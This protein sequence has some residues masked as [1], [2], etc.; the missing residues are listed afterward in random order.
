LINSIEQ[1]VIKFIDEK[2]LLQ[3]KD[4]VLVAFSGGP[5]SVFLLYF[6]NKFKRRFH[7]ELAAL[8][9]NHKLR[10]IEANEDE[11][12]CRDFCKNLSIDFFSVKKD[13]KSFATKRKISL[14]EAGR[15]IRYSELKKNASRNKFNKIATAHNSNDNTETI[16]LNLIKGTGIKGISG[17]PAKR[18]NIIRPMLKLTKHEILDY[19]KQNKLKFRIDSTNLSSDY[20][21]NFLRNEII[22]LIKTKLNPSL[23]DSIFN[24]SE[25]FKK[26]FSLV[27]KNIKPFL[28]SIQFEK[29]QKCLKIFPDKVKSLRKE[30]LGDFL[31]EAVKRNFLVQLSFNDVNNLISL[32]SSKTGKRINLSENLSAIKERE[33]ILIFLKNDESIFVPQKISVNGSLKIGSKNLIIKDAERKDVKMSKDK[34]LEYISGNKT[35]G[36]FIVRS[37]EEG[38]RFFPL[39]LKSN[40][41]IK[42]G[43]KKISDFL[44]EQKIP[45]ILKKKQLVLVC[46]KKI[47]W[48]LGLRLD[49]RFKLTSKTEKIYQLCLK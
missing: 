3:R 14:E 16:L 19:L 42:R 26:F 33:E 15:E 8:H 30:Y 24:S 49:D 39:G 2:N 45:S 37:W 1:K 34:N 44:N 32:F 17:I 36:N 38:D 4:K 13:V 18:D 48:V 46:N 11:E 10:G 25:V 29:K 41:A 23:E 35:G 12:F 43:S 28:T 31:K 22:P 20:E 5:D 21:R 9:V 6:L 27:E 7:V 40:D 47:V